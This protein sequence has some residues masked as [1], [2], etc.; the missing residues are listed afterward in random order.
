MSST[1][2]IDV[3]LLAESW[4]YFLTESEADTSII[5]TPT[6]NILVGVG[7]QEVTEETSVWDI[8][9]SHDSFDLLKAA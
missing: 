2:Q 8:S 4:D 1:D 3:M 6:L 9:G 5:F 7:P